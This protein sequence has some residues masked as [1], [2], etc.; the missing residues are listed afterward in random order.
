MDCRFLEVDYYLR[1]IITG[2][3]RPDKNYR[4][5]AAI[6]KVYRIL[7]EEDALALTKMPNS[8][9]ALLRWN[10]SLRNIAAMVRTHTTGDLQAYVA[11][12]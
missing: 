2:K 3:E 11:S 10:A 6:L 9:D 12:Q 5:G 8:R 1:P 7:A 4:S